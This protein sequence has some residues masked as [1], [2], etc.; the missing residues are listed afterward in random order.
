MGVILIRWKHADC[1][2][3]SL[4]YQNLA[5]WAR[6]LARL[7]SWGWEGGSKL[8]I[9]FPMT[10]VVEMAPVYQNSVQTPGATLWAKKSFS[11]GTIPPQLDMLGRTV[12]NAM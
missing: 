10:A 7:G 4:K 6:Y 3:H 8:V 11:V 12:V 1:A 9:P 2:A 5:L